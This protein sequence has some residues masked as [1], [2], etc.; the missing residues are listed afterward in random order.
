MEPNETPVEPVEQPAEPTPPKLEPTKVAPTVPDGMSL[1]SSDELAKLTRHSEAYAGQSPMVSRLVEAGIKTPEDLDHAMAPL[2]AAKEM[3]LDLTGVV[4]SMK[5]PG[6]EP[7]PQSDMAKLK[8]EILS[9]IDGKTAVTRWEAAQETEDGLARG[10]VTKLVGDKPSDSD[11]MMAEGLVGLM[12]A[13][14]STIYKDGSLKGRIAPLTEKEFASIT[15]A[16]EKTWRA[17]RGQ[18]LSNIAANAGT[19]KPTPPP[20]GGAGAATPPDSKNPGEPPS[21]S[22][23]MAYLEQLQARRGGGPISQA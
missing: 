11:K 23:V 16:A 19:A 21:R 20:P 4:N 7:E 17:E 22:D 10:L 18:H 3:G 9:E 1:V 6:A 2:A 8:A 12:L 5:M 14:N 15:E 13:R